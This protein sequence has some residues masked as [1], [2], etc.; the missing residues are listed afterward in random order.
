MNEQV[1]IQYSADTESARQAFALIEQGLNRLAD[2]S[3]KSATALDR[4]FERIEKGSEKGHKALEKVLG[5]LEKIARAEHERETRR[6]TAGVAVD[7]AMRRVQSQG[8]LS[9]ATALALR[10][11]IAAE[12][13]RTAAPNF[14]YLASVASTLL[15]KGMS[16]KQIQ[17][18]GLANVADFLAANNIRGSN[19][20]PQQAVRAMSDVLRARNLPATSAGFGQVADELYGFTQATGMDVA[21]ASTILTGMA[22]AG[23]STRSAKLLARYGMTR[24]D[25]DVERHGLGGV[26][27]ILRARTAALD[28]N[29]RA[30]FFENAFGDGAGTAL[31]QMFVEFPS[32]KLPGR[33]AYR[34]DVALATGGIAA[35]RRRQDLMNELAA[36][37]HAEHAIRTQIALEQAKIIREEA[38]GVGGSA[39]GSA[40]VGGIQ[41]TAVGVGYQSGEGYLRKTQEYYGQRTPTI[42]ELARPVEIHIENNLRRSERAELHHAPLI[43][44][45]SK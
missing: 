43:N 9:D 44:L 27:Q 26:L 19:V 36:A 41:E 28:V 39:Y 11:T 24:Q 32:L 45:N 16:A 20:D 22:R 33:G 8:G 21:Q 35:D 31:S 17:A 29:E 10:S 14:G 38:G 13:H 6:A 40:I 30:S 12:A 1:K 5:M 37:R 25:L 34:R 2:S 23:V 15:Q 18:G 7:E 3:G 4:V 42:V